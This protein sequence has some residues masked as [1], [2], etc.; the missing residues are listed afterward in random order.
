MGHNSKKKKGGGGRK[1]KRRVQSKDNPSL[2]DDDPGLL[3]EEVIALSAIFQE[4]FKLVSEPP[5]AQFTINIRPHLNDSGLEDLSASAV[6]HIRCL[7]GYPYKCPK[8]RIVPEK[9]LSEDDTEHL[10]A[11]LLDQANSNAREGRVM[12]FNLVETAQEFLS[13]VATVV[14]SVKSV[15]ADKK[16]ELVQESVTHVCDKKYSFG[17]HFVYGLIDLFSDLSADVRSWDQSIISDSL[18]SISHGQLFSSGKSMVGSSLAHA[19]VL[20]KSK[21]DETRVLNK[22][23]S[24]STKPVTVADTPKLQSVMPKPQSVIPKPQSVIPKPQSA[25]PKPQSVIPKPQSGAKLEA[26]NEDIE[27]GG[28][29]VSTDSTTSLEDRTK[30][31]NSL[32]GVVRVKQESLFQKEMDMDNDSNDANDEAEDDE[33]DDDSEHW[34]SLPSE[35]EAENEIS[36]PPINKDLVVIHLLRLACSSKGLLAGSLAEIASDLHNLGIISEWARNLATEPSLVFSEAFGGVFKQH[37]DSSLASRFWKATA[38]FGE[39]KSSSSLSSR[40]LNDF[41]EVCSL[42]HGGFGHVMLCKNKLDGRQYAVKKIQLKDKSLPI[43]NKILREVATLSRLQHQHV[44]RYYQAWFETEIGGY[45]V[46][47]T[48]GSQSGWSSMGSCSVANS[49]SVLGVEPKLEST[50][51]YIQMEYC[52]RTLR[53]VFESCTGLFDKET[54]W[55]LFRQIVEGLAHIHGQGIIHRDLTPSNIFFDARNDIKIGDFGLAKF[56]KLEQLDHDASFPTES[57]GMSMDGTGQVGTYFYTAPEIEQRWPQINEKVD[58]YSLGV[59]FFELWHP[60]STAMER[61]AVLSELKQT[62]ILPPAWVA[63]FPEQ[64]SLLKRLMS[65]SPSD[66]PSARELLQNALPPRMED[67]WLN[68]ILRTIQT[69]DD[70]Y[71][72]DRVVS[73]IFDERRLTLKS[74]RQHA[75]RG[76]MNNE[77]F[78]MQYTEFDTS[79][80]DNVIEV[81]K[82][83]FRRHGAKR[84]EIAPLHLLDENHQ[85]DRKSIKLLTSGGNMLELCHELRLSFANWVARNQILSFKR[86]EISWVYRRAVGHSTPNRYLQGDFDIIGGATAVTEA[87]VIKVVVEVVTHFFHPSVCDIRLNHG[88]IFDAIWSWI[89]IEGDLRQNVA[90][91]LSFMG[92]A[93][94]QSSARKSRWGLIR[95]QL[96]QELNLSEVV[97]NRLKTVDLRF[98]GSADLALARLRGALPSDKSIR[99]ALDELSALITYLRVWKIENHVS[100]D[101]LMPPT[102]GYYREL[103]FQLYTVKDIATGSSSEGTLLAVGGR[104]DHLFQQIWFHEYKS[105]FAGA[106]GTS[107]ALEKLLHLS[108]TEIKPSRNEQSM[109]VLICSRGGGGLL[110]ER[111]E[112]AAELWQENIKTEFVPVA[113]PNLTEQYEYANEHDIKCIVIVTGSGLSQTDS[114]KVRHLELKKEKEVQRAGLIKF[115]TEAMSTQFRNLSIWN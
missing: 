43:N 37:M 44:V 64:S 53:Q 41:E 50:Y 25:I 5:H 90:K 83:V 89:G 17:E 31:L 110:L 58:M 24:Q 9:G 3:S 2:D 10:L 60:F 96:L 32:N 57:A 79:L 77:Q 105:S 35:S 6:L 95:R 26:V 59:V 19:Y 40:Y 8:L 85:S 78:F 55:H 30:S 111:M 114:V 107:I 51:L 87:E 54:T 21:L 100:I 29:S 56:L 103:F 80:R 65:L 76:K 46:E 4:D 22:H 67:E 12:I 70:T 101:V 11:L 14:G 61:H 86:Y 112:L 38:D 81:T 49:A 63:E 92:S 102:D 71:V 88:R 15:G 27:D 93:R 62:G 115:L 113:D 69:A 20:D 84:M 18:G 98:C 47:S 106:V 94:P 66:R 33:D 68:D 109:N 1:N 72:Y 45:D 73:T 75:G 97:V 104:Y 34:V 23:F 36:Q 39:E 42:G 7:P 74:N 48:L 13:E 108:S 99:N 91:L 16:E 28:Q 52:P 82:D